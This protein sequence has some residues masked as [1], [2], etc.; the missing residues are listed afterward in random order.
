MTITE[1]SKGVGDEFD[2]FDEF[3]EQLWALIFD[4]FPLPSLLVNNYLEVIVDLHKLIE[5]VCAEL[6]Q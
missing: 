2:E 4:S 1:V 5:I 6:P 3:D